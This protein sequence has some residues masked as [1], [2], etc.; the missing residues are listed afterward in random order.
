MLKS[1]SHIIVT[2]RKLFICTQSSLS[3]PLFE[4]CWNTKVI[5]GGDPQRLRLSLCVAFRKHAVLDSWVFLFSFSFLGTRTMWKFPGQGS[6][7][8][9]TSDPNCCSDN[10]RSLTH[11]AARN[12]WRLFLF[13]FLPLFFY[14]IF[15][16]FRA[17]LAEYGSFQ[18]RGWIRATAA[19]LSHSYSTAG[20]E[21]HLWP[22]PQ[23]RA[24]LDPQ[25]TGWV[26]E[27]NP[28]PHGYYLDLFPLRYSRN[29]QLFIF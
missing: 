28:H 8:C 26:Q 14:F 3:Y 21:L 24:T 17:T 4:I 25:P 2:R 10:D 13:S 27:L 5:W 7:L 16:L 29:Y 1:I 15:C 9:H 11:C 6:K 18:A 22:T 19:G 20:C 12:S 23:L